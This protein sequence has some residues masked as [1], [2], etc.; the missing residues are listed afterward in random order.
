MLPFVKPMIM[1]KSGSEFLN[2]CPGTIF[3]ETDPD[4]TL[5]VNSPVCERWNMTAMLQNTAAYVVGDFGPGYFGT[6]FEIQWSS[7]KGSGGDTA[8][9]VMCIVSDEPIGTWRKQ[10][11]NLSGGMGVWNAINL[12]QTF[13]GVGDFALDNDSFWYQG[14]Y[15][16]GPHWFTLSRVGNSL[17][18]YAYSDAERTSQIAAK[19]I[20][21]HA[22]N[23]FRYL[24]ILGSAGGPATDSD[25][26]TGWTEQYKIVSH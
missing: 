3:T 25:P 13:I 15:P 1:K 4:G 12:G 14:A 9:C 26:Y 6:T 17:T 2:V 21:C 22:T 7:F 19:N 23:T 24:I 5:S 11:F 8:K 18:M 10:V 16:F 20:T